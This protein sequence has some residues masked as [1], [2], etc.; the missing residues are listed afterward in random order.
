MTRNDSS[1]AISNNTF[2]FS[3]GD[4]SSW[5]KSPDMT[6][7]LQAQGAEPVGNSPAELQH[8]LQSEITRWTKVIRAAK[9]TAN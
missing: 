9:I 7:Q 8:F 4:P 3:I 5:L 6:E 2:P 1:G